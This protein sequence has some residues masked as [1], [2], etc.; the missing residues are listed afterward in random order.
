MIDLKT[1]LKAVDRA[2]IQVEQSIADSKSPAVRQSLEAQL[3]MFRKKARS[4]MRRE[5]RKLA[6]IHQNDRD[7]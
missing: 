4:F 2:I 7:W 1:R 5:S 3:A 6:K